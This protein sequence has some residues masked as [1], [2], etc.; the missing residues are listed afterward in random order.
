V[1]PAEPDGRWLALP[2]G[3]D[4]RRHA[5]LVRLAA[6]RHALSARLAAR[7]QVLPARPA[8]RRH[9]L[10]ASG[11]PSR[12]YW[13]PFLVKNKST[14]AQRLAERRLRPG[15]TRSG[16]AATTLLWRTAF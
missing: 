6:R 16:S 11:R 15:P 3:P 1:L 13:R 5:L 10:S 7:R 9:A 2:A 4:G 8:A 14:P 12:R